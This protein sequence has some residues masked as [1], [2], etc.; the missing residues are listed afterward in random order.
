MSARLFTQVQDQAAKWSKTLQPKKCSVN[1][2]IYSSM[3][4]QSLSYIHTTL[5]ELNNGNI[6]PCNRI[7]SAS[8][9]KWEMASHLVNWTNGFPCLIGQWCS[10]IRNSLKSMVQKIILTLDMA[11]GFWTILV[12]PHGH[13]KLPLIFVNKQYTFTWLPFGYANS[14]TKFNKACPDMRAW[15][16]LIYVDEILMRST[17]IKAHL[18]E[19]DHVLEQLAKAGTKIILHKHQWCKAK[20]KIC[21]PDDWPKWCWIPVQLHSGHTEY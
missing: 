15:G 21:W 3:G 5:Q 14:P 7:Y 17:T 10:W 9:T 4:T 6:H 8:Q 16:S 13:H 2:Q 12:H 1:V 11:P 19:S 20:E 18:A